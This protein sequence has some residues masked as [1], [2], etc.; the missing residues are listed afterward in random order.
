MMDF[1]KLMIYTDVDGTAATNVHHISKVSLENISA[2]REFIEKGGKFGVASGRGHLS[3]DQIFGNLDINLPYIEAN[4]ASVWDKNT[5]HHL[6]LHYVST[7]SKVTLY[8][9]VKNNP[10]LILTAMIDKSYKVAFNDRRDSVIVDFERPMLNFDDYVKSN[11]LKCAILSNKSAID[12]TLSGISSFV[13]INDLTISRSADIYLEIFDKKASKGNGIKEVIKNDKTL[14]ERKLVCI[15][16][17]HNDL[18]MLKI[19]D[20]AICPKNAVNEVKEICT[21]IAKP[22]YENTLVDVIEYLR[23]L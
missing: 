7:Q 8:N 12:R 16:D 6:S 9:F 21:Y 5:N 18:S 15:G 23:R 19:A 22:N 13:D 17:Y 3:I 20:I 10:E 1:S 14:H 2:C 11:L 4:G